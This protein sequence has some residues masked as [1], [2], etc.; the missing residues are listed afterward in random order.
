[1][2]K[3]LLCGDPHGRFDH[4]IQAVP[5]YRPDAVIL[6]GDM[7]PDRPL[8]VEL[9]RILNLTDVWWIPGNHDTDEER[10]YDNVFG[11]ELADRNLHGRVVEIAGLSVAGLGGVFREKIWMPGK[12]DA[13]FHSPADYLAKCGKGN[14]WR[15]G[16]PLKHRSTIF[17]SEV[18]SLACQRADVLVS[19]E[20]PDLH[21]FGS[22]ALTQ[23][24]K[25]LG[26]R[27][28][29]HGHHHLDM[30]YPERVWRQVAIRN[31]FCFT[32]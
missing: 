25:D 17:P 13:K 16:L 6:L 20:G 30:A 7:T 8:H 5:A 24:A 4:I 29:F 14:R 26:V 32:G 9:A 21:Q 2:P 27:A 12:A 23:L 28:A 11:S 10:F 1:M 15:H 18:E 22:P 19:H 3:I 31:V